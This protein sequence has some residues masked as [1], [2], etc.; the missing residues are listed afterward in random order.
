MTRYSLRRL[1]LAPPACT[2]SRRNLATTT[3]QSAAKITN[4]T[5]ATRIF[6]LGLVA[7]GS[8]DPKWNRS[9]S[10]KLVVPSVCLGLSEVATMEGRRYQVCGVPAQSLHWLAARSR[11]LEALITASAEDIMPLVYDIKALSGGADYPALRLLLTA[12]L[13]H[14][15]SLDSAG[16]A[17][18]LDLNWPLLPQ[19]S[20]YQRVRRL[21]RARGMC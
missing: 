7:L 18:Q 9:D 21:S 16:D 12:F 6:S 8:L 10:Y 4:L 2:Q 11:V 5:Q 15:F 13:A 3:L 14:A 1:H 17:S 20:L 19:V